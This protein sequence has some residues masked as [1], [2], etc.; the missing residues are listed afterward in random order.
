MKSPMFYPL[1]FIFNVVECLQNKIALVISYSTVK[2]VSCFNGYSKSTVNVK[3]AK[4]NSKNVK[5]KCL[6]YRHL[7]KFNNFKFNKS[8]I[9]FDV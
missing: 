5:K 1:I 4:A 8:P 2:N 9:N 3:F 7:N 6:M